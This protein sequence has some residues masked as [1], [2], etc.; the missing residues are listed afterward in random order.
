MQILETPRLILR[1]FVP[2]DVAALARVLSD[3][4]TMPSAPIKPGLAKTQPRKYRDPDS[5]QIFDL[6]F[7]TFTL[8]RR[9]KLPLN[10]SCVIVALLLQQGLMQSP[11]RSRITQIPVEVV[12]KHSLRAGRVPAHKQHT[13]QRFAHRK[14]PIG[15]LSILQR[16]L[17]GNGFP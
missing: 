5:H 8:P 9:L 15:R 17:D 12:T 1:E 2:D 13:S 3:P 10:K 4:E 7:L 6:Q 11:Q 16:V 14:E